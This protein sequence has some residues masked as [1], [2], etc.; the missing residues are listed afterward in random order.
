MINALVTGS[1][2]FIAKNFIHQNINNKVRFLLINKK[3]KINSI[4]NHLSKAD[5]IFHFAG[6][7]RS[8]KKYDFYKDNVIFTT[9]LVKNNINN[10]PIVYLSSVKFSE[11]SVYGKTK[12]KAEKILTRFCKINKTPLY[13][14]RLPN[15]FGKWSKP[16]Y[17]SVVSTF[18]FNILKNKKIENRFPNKKITLLYID[19]LINF[20]NKILYK[21]FFNK[22][23]IVFSKFNSY[24]ITLKNLETIIRSFKDLRK[25]YNF[26]ILRSN[27]ASKLYS[28]YISFCDKN[29]VVYDFTQ[30][31]DYRGKFVEFFKSKKL[32]QISFF[33]IYPG[34]IRGEHFHHSKTE[35]FLLIK[36]KVEMR[37][38]NISNN[39]SFKIILSDKKNNIIETIPG[40]YHDIK[41]ISK[42]EA[43][44]LL[45][46]NQLFNIKKP[47]T[48]SINYE[49]I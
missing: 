2:G 34:Q 16:N 40:Y 43:I 25:K 15:V 19:D 5:L 36:G 46:S 38:K 10:A 18:C 22:K 24:S 37:F 31:S 14:L 48:I 20:L 30:K 13:I 12:K 39:K 27:L 47:D 35:K 33:S 1:N 21:K 44:V 6:T 17:N 26:D 9:L 41:N 3:S 49:K 29:D 23:K 4:K 42:K 32:G 7:N 45:W 11:N 8:E 28:T